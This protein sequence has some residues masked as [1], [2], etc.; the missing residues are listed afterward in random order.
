MNSNCEF[1]QQILIDNNLIKP[2]VFIIFEYLETVENVMFQLEDEIQ[3]KHNFNLLVPNTNFEGLL[4]YKDHPNHIRQYINMYLI[5][6]NRLIFNYFKYYSATK[7]PLYSTMYFINN[8]TKILTLEEA[9]D[10]T[11]WL[12]TQNECKIL[13]RKDFSNQFEYIQALSIQ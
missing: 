5:K 8:N 2:I 7:S 3:L 10:I 4:P 1:I 12:P 6:R 9:L 13:T 11:N